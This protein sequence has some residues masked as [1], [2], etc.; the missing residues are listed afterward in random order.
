MWESLRQSQR[1]EQRQKARRSKSL[2]DASWWAWKAHADH[3]VFWSIPLDK[4]TPLSSKPLTKRPAYASKNLQIVQVN[5]IN[6]FPIPSIY[7]AASLGI[8]CCLRS[9]SFVF[10]REVGVIC[11]IFIGSGL[12]F[13]LF[14]VSTTAIDTFHTVDAIGL[15][16]LFERD[17]YFSRTA[18][19]VRS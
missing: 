6:P 17:C 18:A 10:R 2:D 13:W 7:N 11:I 16:L 19:Y 9:M 12:I 8:D 5:A 4:Q 14:L 1:L 3:S 15:C